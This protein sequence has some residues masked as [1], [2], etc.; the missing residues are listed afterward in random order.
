MVS[1]TICVPSECVPAL[2]G[3]NGK[4]HKDT[5]NI[6]RKKI[7]FKRLNSDSHKAHIFGKPDNIM[8]AIKM[9]D[10]A[11]KHFKASVSEDSQE[12]PEPPG[13]DEAVLDCNMFISETLRRKC[14]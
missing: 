5:E 9:I 4:K 13:K 2:L 11:I 1:E 7:C 3:L 12:D 8:L 10:L 6:S 14:Y